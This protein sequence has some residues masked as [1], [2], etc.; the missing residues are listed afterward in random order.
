MNHFFRFP[1]WL[2]LSLLIFSCSDDEDIV[3]DVPPLAQDGYFIVNEGAFNN[4]NTSLS[5]YDRTNDTV[6]N[7]VFETANN[8][9]LGD[10]TQS[11]TVIDDRGFIVV[12]NSAKIEVINANDFTTIATITENIVSPR[13]LIGV[14]DT[15][16]YLTDWGADGVTGTIK[17]IDLNAYE[18][19]KTIPIG[20]GPNKLALVDNRVYVANGGGFG[21]DSTLMVL[22]T[23]TD[24]VV[25]TVVVG[26]NPS[27]LAVDANGDL[28]IAGG[29]FVSYDPNDFSVIEEESTVGFI[30]K[31]ENDTVSRRLEA[32]QINTGPSDLMVNARG[33]DLYFRYAGGVY[34]IRPDAVALLER[35]LIDRR[36]YGLA[37]DPVSGE[38]LA[39]EAPNF[40]TEGTFYRYTPT[41]ELIRSYTVG[42]A[43]NGF[44]F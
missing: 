6:L 25:D 37:V 31:L 24:T 44:A 18:V 38:I 14:D 12:Q 36:F 22:D 34:T 29:G 13:Y 33:T 16:A 8:R 40:S 9:P 20:K 3:I 1:V 26:D 19:T 11:M 35:P 27:S 23:T 10:Q 5:Y 42:I 43:P 39:G 4:A 7:N 21:R 41:G 2:A 32:T 28:W 30:V 15:K 17:V